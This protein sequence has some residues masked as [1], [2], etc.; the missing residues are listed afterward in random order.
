MFKKY[1]F[2]ALLALSLFVIAPIQ[3]M[4]ANI[5]DATLTQFFDAVK[6][7]DL[8]TVRTLV[9]Q[10]PTI[11]NAIDPDMV[12]KTE[13]SKRSVPGRQWHPKGG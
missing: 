6:A 11:V 7:C 2:T 8:A 1:H 12:N 9:K 13:P 3:S 4:E 5:D 10:N